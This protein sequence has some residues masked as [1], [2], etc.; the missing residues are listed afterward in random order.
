VLQKG[1]PPVA[2]VVYHALVRT[3]HLDQLVLLQIT[4]AEGVTEL[5]I[6]ASVASGRTYVTVE[7]L[8]V[9]ILSPRRLL[10]LLLFL[11]SFLHFSASL[12]H[13]LVAPIVILLSL[14]LFLHARQML[15][16]VPLVYFGHN[17]SPTFGRHLLAGIAV[18]FDSGCSGCGFCGVGL[19]TAG[20]GLVTVF[21]L[22]VGALIFLFQKGFVKRGDL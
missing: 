4:T 18:L 22:N 14:T 7:V 12:E 19:V 16:S 17:P 6:A 2:R 13:C 10:F 11:G 5:V 21:F 3:F 1:R 9:G 15:L 20:A 8:V